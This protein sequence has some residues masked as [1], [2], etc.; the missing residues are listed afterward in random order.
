VKAHERN[1]GIKS[2]SL[3]ETMIIDIVKD[4]MIKLGYQWIS[5]YRI[6]KIDS[7]KYITSICYSDKSNCGFLIE[8]ITEE[9]PLQENRNIKSLNKKYSKFDYTEKIVSTNGKY[10]FINIPEIPENLHILKMDNYWY[11]I[12]TNKIENIDLVSKE[13]IT[14]LLRQDVRGF[15]KPVSK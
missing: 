5:N 1:S 4:E 11:Q 6:I 2:F 12:S 15:L 7:A 8:H 3:T 13:F 9:V 10:E 14:E